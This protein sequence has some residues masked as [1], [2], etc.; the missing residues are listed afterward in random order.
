M[1]TKFLDQ[2]QLT[3]SVTPSS[4][5]ITS[6]DNGQVVAEKSQG[7]INAINT[8]TGIL[9]SNGSTVSTAV[10]GNFPTLNQN[11]TGTTTYCT[12]IAGGA[13]NRIPYQTSSGVT[14][15]IP[16]ANN[17]IVIES[18]GTLSF[19]S[20]PNFINCNSS[21]V[22]DPTTSGTATIDTADTNIYAA[23]SQKT[24]AT[25]GTNK[26]NTASN[27]GIFY[28]DSST[29]SILAGTS[30]ANKTLLSGSNAAPSWSTTT[31]PTS[32]GN[33]DVVYASSAN[34]LG[35]ISG[36]DGGIYL[37]NGSGVPTC[38]TTTTGYYAGTACTDGNGTTATQLDTALTNIYNTTSSFSTR[39]YYTAN[40]GNVSLSSTSTSKQQVTGASITISTAGYYLISFNC[41]QTL[42]C[43]AADIGYNLISKA[44]MWVNG[45][46]E[47]FAYTGFDDV[48]YNGNEIFS[49]NSSTMYIDGFAGS[50]TIDVY[51]QLTNATA[52]T[53]TFIANATITAYRIG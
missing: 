39:A 16:T 1:T 3:S 44:F 19:T 10:A 33:G 35:G 51:V 13:A 48:V 17:A 14:T 24:L 30:T 20:G 15:F 38:T 12:N 23:I 22:I 4:S 49:G 53:D 37:T 5:A 29:I 43:Q 27:G 47:A 34:T 42:T 7:Q 50:P 6:G 11:T 2:L 41:Y 46:Q 9:Y 52:G 45:S 31:F 26:N 32:Y 18:G 8:T 28:S 40:S 36:V 21:N 25:G